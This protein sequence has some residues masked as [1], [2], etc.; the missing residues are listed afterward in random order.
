LTVDYGWSGTVVPSK[1][2]YTFEPNSMPHDNVVTDQSDSCIATL[3][4]FIISG[5]AV[6][7]QMYALEGVLVSPENDGGPFTSKYYGGSYTTG[8]DGYYEVRVDYNFSG[9]VV[10]SKYAY[11]FEP[12]SIIYNNVT[13][14]N[15]E[16]QYYVG[17]LLTYTITGCIKNAFDMPIEGVLVSADN[18]GG[19]DITDANGTYEVWV[20]YN[21]SGTVTPAKAH[22]TFDPPA[23][24]Y[25]NVLYDLTDQ[26]YT[27]ANI[28]DLYADGAIDGFDLAVFCANWLT[29]APECDYVNDGMVNAEDF[30]EFAASWQNE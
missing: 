1:T 25:V 6:D 27:A 5:Y 2:G 29:A 28:F 10:P 13:E 17:T 12:N 18:G 4:T 7:S 20:G 19:S 8:P 9:K 14:D 24:G 15:A 30:T 23:G 11:A 26:D 16:Q 21:W 22:Y 3:D